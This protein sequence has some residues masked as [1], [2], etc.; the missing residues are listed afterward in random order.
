MFTINCK[1]RLLVVDKPI[2]MGI[3]NI[4]PDSFYTESRK[5]EPEAVLKQ[6]EKMLKEGAS[7]L[8][9]GG[10]STRPGST[11]L[12]PQEEWQRVQ[13]AIEVLLRH[14]PEA[15]ISIDTFYGSVAKNAIDAGA[16]MVND[17][18]GG[19]M[20]QD[21]IRLVAAA[22]VPFICMHMKGTPQNMQQN[23]VYENV[24][25]EVLDFF[26]ERT[27]TCKKA[28]IKDVI[29]DPGFGFGKTTTQ[30]FRLLKSLD[31]FSML[32]KP[33]L[34][35]ISRKSF[36][37]KTLGVNAEEALNGST[38]LHMLALKNG[39]KI[40]RVHDTKEAKETIKLFM[41]YQQA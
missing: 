36:V 26:I 9:I 4:T 22:S 11:M 12:T 33:M 20:D 19:M 30:N 35:G 24:V 14:F 27:A 10:Q 29:I 23:A 38:A 7:I 6:A 40:L 37:Y 13:P 21:M 16:R 2:V 5:N 3:I 28:G 18:S 8:D 39:A 31:I 34:V 17:V 32:A 15:I 41:E 1:G 25:K